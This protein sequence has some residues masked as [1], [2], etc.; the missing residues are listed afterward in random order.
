MIVVTVELLQPNEIMEIVREL[1]KQ[2]LD[3]GT[4]FD[5]S[6]EPQEYDPISG[7]H[8]PRATKFMFHS[9][10]YATLFAIKYST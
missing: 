3:Q 5:F 4:D 8:K 9:E 7:H 10:K 6:Y 2:G 1:R